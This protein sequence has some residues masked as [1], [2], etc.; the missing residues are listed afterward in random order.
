MLNVYEQQYDRKHL[1]EQF[2]IDVED[3]VQFITA[4]QN[5]RG[6]KYGCVCYM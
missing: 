3:E 5:P 4:A 1:N 2:D 6:K